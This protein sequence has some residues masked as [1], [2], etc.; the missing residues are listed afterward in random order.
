MK[1][2]ARLLATA[3]MAGGLVALVVSGCG[4]QDSSI[5]P[6]RA[7]TAPAPPRVVEDQSAKTPAEEAADPSIETT[8]PS[9]ET[10][11]PA[12]PLFEESLEEQPPVSGAEEEGD[13]EGPED[14]EGAVEPE[15][16]VTTT[17]ATTSAPTTAA[18]Q[19]PVT[20]GAESGS[21]VLD[22]P[23]ISNSFAPEYLETWEPINDPTGENW[24]HPKPPASDVSP[25]E[26]PERIAYAQA[27]IQTMY[28]HWY[29]GIYRKDPASLHRAVADQSSYE[30]GV[31]AMET[32]TFSSPPT[33][34]GV[35]VG[36][37]ELYIDNPD[38]IVAHFQMDVGAFL[39]GSQVNESVIVLW[40]HPEYGW[41]RDTTLR[42]PTIYGMWWSN[43]FL[44]ERVEF[45]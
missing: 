12:A 28:F 39:S 10:T 21:A 30:R 14:P 17:T 7:S 22:G 25:V 3:V 5:R 44:T 34:E 36:V 13:I 38:C 20:I 2:G 23:V 40:R 31:G 24:A 6:E 43:C 29:D 45:P 42:I 26:D 1:A 35:V 16:A 18:P 32:M 19:P 41:R 27:Q 37:V 15:G 4:S 11:A 33:L 8:A 9:S